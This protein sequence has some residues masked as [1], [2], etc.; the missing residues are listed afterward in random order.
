MG[1]SQSSKGAPGNVPLVP[2]WADDDEKNPNQSDDSYTGNDDKAPSPPKDLPLAPA[3]RFKGARTNINSFA[4]N[5]ETDKLRRGVGQYIKTGYGGS[6]TAAKR[7]SRTINTAGVLFDF[8]SSISTGQTSTG[9]PF[10]DIDIN[11]LVGKDEDEIT[12]AIINAVRPIDGDLDSEASQNSIKEAFSELLEKE[13]NTDLLNLTDDQRLFVVEKFVANDVFAR[14]NLDMGKN[15]LDNAPTS[16][17]ASRLKEAK[18]YIREAVYTKFREKITKDTVSPS[19]IRILIREVLTEAFEIF[20]S[21][22]Q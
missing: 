12:D 22:A 6:K 18:D 7:L 8:L 4:K 10:Q 19:S 1:T 21:Y 11:A 2:P 15:I 5:G 16:V 3:G 17:A 14:F 20:E 9:E 13:D